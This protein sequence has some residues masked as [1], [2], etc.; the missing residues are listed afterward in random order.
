MHAGRSVHGLAFR[1]GG[2][3]RVEGHGIPE[4]GLG[5]ALR[6]THRRR[7]SASVREAQRVVDDQ[8]DDEDGRRRTT[9][10]AH[11]PS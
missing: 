7:F 8:G 10:T 9:H 6:R 3:A 4:C 5:K 2:R 1:H 11:Q